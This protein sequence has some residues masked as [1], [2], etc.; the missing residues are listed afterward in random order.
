[1][2]GGRK[3]KNASKQRM[4]KIYVVSLWKDFE[5]QLQE[6]KKKQKEREEAV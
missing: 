1:M 4:K 5:G 2:I 6:E 3:K